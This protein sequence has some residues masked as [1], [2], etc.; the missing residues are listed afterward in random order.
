MGKTSERPRKSRRNRAIFFSIGEFRFVGSPALPEG[1]TLTAAV[2]SFCTDRDALIS[3][4]ISARSRSSAVS[5][6]TSSEILA[7]ICVIEKIGMHQNNNPECS[8]L[9]LRSLIA[10]GRLGT[11]AESG[12]Q[13]I[14]NFV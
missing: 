8:D 10:V 6:A 4:T 5:R 11:T 2:L 14:Q 3:A 9:I 12:C 1:T 13:P 7:S